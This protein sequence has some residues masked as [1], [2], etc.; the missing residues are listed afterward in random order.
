MKEKETLLMAAALFAALIV[1]LN[2]ILFALGKSSIRTCWFII[3][4][5]AIFAYYILPGL[6]KKK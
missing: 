4:A 3:I 6:R 1:I 5:A 2:I